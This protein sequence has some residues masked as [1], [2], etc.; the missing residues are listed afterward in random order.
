MKTNE[1]IRLLDK[2]TI[3]APNTDR[4]GNVYFGTSDEGLSVGWLHYIS[5]V[6]S[7]LGG[8]EHEI[9]FVKN[10]PYW[11]QLYQFNGC[12][13]FEDKFTLFGVHGHGE[14]SESAYPWDWILAC[15]EHDAAEH[16]DF[17]NIQEYTPIG[18]STY[19]KFEKTLLQKRD[20]SIIG[21]NLKAGDLMNN[22]IDVDDLIS[23]EVTRLS[24]QYAVN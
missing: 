17:G 8:V 2:K 18:I 6:P 10:H 1:L 14:G 4:H 9:E 24:S 13:L 21:V 19:E 5:A 22:W 12:S 3:L 23:S 7:K 20:S 15:L 16:N 11:Q